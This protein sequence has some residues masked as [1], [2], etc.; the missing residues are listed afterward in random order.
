MKQNAPGRSRYRRTTKSVC[1]GLVRL[2][3]R[4][5]AMCLKRQEVIA[6]PAKKYMKKINPDIVCQDFSAI[7]SAKN[8]IL[9]MYMMS[10]VSGKLLYL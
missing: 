7:I 10:K 9:R 2:T 1:S 5:S 6:E 4:L 8:R 3:G